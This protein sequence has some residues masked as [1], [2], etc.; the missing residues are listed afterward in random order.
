MRVKAEHDFAELEAV[1]VGERPRDIGVGQLVV[2][3]DER[4]RLREILHEPPVVGIVQ[5]RVPAAHG[6]RPKSRRSAA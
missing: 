5:S 4:I 6:R 3:D 1:A 2:V